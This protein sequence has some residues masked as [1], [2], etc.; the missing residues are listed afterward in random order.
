MMRRTTLP[1]LALIGL[2][3]MYGTP[4]AFAS[5]YFGPSFQVTSTSP[6]GNV[7]LTVST[8]SSNTFVA[9]P[10]G[11][12]AQCQSDQVC[13][14]PLQS[15]TDSSTFY[16][17]IHEITITDADGN[18]Y[19]LGSSATSGM[20]WPTILGGQAPGPN[21][22]PLSDGVGT[23]GDALNVTTG[24]AFVLPFGA[25]AGGFT[26]TTS[27]GSPP[28]TNAPEGPYYWWTIAGNTYGSNLRLDQ[29][30]GINPTTTPGTYVAD[31][32][33][34]VVC[35]AGVFFDEGIQVF[36]DQGSQFTV[37]QF[38]GPLVALVAVGFAA[39]ILLSKKNRV[40]SPV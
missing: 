35:G 11:S 7:Y 2:V 14:Y 25:G 5:T 9:P 36:F 19:M 37:P 12:G 28:Q 22:L 39:T 3:A 1:L 32:E 15:C 30:P 31:F 16:Y 4:A 38:S 20:Y 26:F 40:V 27:L 23:L 13:S 17:S 8:T 6:G 10:E 24:D 29:N 33:G 18:G 21:T 34:V